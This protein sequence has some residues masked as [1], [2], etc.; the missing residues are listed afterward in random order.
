M[1]YGGSAEKSDSFSLHSLQFTLPRFQC[2]LSWQDI[3]A[4]HPVALVNHL[5]LGSTAVSQSVWW[6][7]L[8]ER[9][10][11]QKGKPEDADS[12]AKV[13]A[14]KTSTYFKCRF[15]L[16]LVSNPFLMVAR[17]GK[18]YHDFQ[19]LSK[20][21]LQWKENKVENIERSR[22]CGWENARESTSIKPYLQSQSVLFSPI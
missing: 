21:K 12:V 3:P 6:I 17:R 22:G 18:Q 11:L 2:R 1:K 9:D 7:S 14:D 8:L 5:A 13:M 4:C 19:L 15:I 16:V 20:G 10:H